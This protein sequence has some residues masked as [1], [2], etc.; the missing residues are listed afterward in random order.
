MAVRKRG[1]RSWGAPRPVGQERGF[2]A[3]VVG[4]AG[5][6]VWLVGST[7][8]GGSLE[9]AGPWLPSRP[10]HPPICLTLCFQEDTRAHRQRLQKHLAEHLRQTW[11]RPGAPPQAG[12]LGELL[13]AWGAGARTGAPKGSRFTHSEKFTFHL[14][15]GPECTGGMLMGPRPAW[16]GALWTDTTLYPHRFLCYQWVCPL[17]TRGEYP[18]GSPGFSGISLEKG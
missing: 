13:Q 2:R 18:E 6:R 9:E 7:L 15:G 4:E 1:P 11:G 5:G 16:R 3:P 12:D 10:L 17:P 8:S 14:V